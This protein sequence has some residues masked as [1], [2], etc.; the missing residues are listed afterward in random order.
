MNWPV[1]TPVPSQNGPTNTGTDKQQGSM[2]LVPRTSPDT[3]TRVSMYVK[4]PAARA[5]GAATG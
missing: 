2:L 4:R 5:T 3:M 1:R